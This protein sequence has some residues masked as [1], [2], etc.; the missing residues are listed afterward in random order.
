MLVRVVSQ[1]CLDQSFIYTFENT[2]NLSSVSS[3]EALGSELLN[4]FA[5]GSGF[6]RIIGIVNARPQAYIL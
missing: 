6:D 5:S 4:V 3:M 2:T 1:F